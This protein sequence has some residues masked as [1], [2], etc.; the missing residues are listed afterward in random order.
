MPAPGQSIEQP[1]R[2]SWSWR[3]GTDVWLD[4]SC[5]SMRPGDK[6]QNI[7]NPTTNFDSFFV[8]EHVTGGKNYLFDIEDKKVFDGANGRQHGAIK[9]ADP[10][11]CL[12]VHDLQHVLR[13]GKL[14][15]SPPFSQAAVT[16]LHYEPA[17]YKMQQR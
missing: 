16:V 6:E 2:R 12:A 8:N 17:G 1:G 14:L 10:A 9:G 3:L 5:S 7:R 15:L 4:G 11:D 13:D